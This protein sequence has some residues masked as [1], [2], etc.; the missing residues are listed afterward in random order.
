MAQRFPTDKPEPTYCNTKEWDRHSWGHY[1]ARIEKS[2]ATPA[3]A[4]MVQDLQLARAAGTPS[5]LP[6]RI[7][8]ATRALKQRIRILHVPM[9]FPT[10]HTPAPEVSQ[11]D[12]WAV[13]CARGHVPRFQQARGHVPDQAWEQASRMGEAFLTKYC[14]AAGAVRAMQTSSL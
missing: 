8:L 6:V 5:H 14:A 2:F 12:Q 3:G 1:V 11:V 9:A 7:T 10:T 4:A 13:D